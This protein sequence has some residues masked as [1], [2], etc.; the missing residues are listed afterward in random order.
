M[1]FPWLVV[2]GDLYAACVPFIQD[3]DYAPLIVDPDAVGAREISLQLLQVVA[4][5][6]EV[7]ELGSRSDL[8]ELAAR[9]RPNVSGNGPRSPG[10]VAVVNVSCGFVPVGRDHWEQDI[11]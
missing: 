1:A 6:C 11:Y 4:R 3:E 9:N 10:V 2:V 5:T 8:V 7:G